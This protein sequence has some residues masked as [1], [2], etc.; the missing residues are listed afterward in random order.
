MGYLLKMF[1][2]RKK[3]DRTIPLSFCPMDGNSKNGRIDWLCLYI[4]NVINDC[5]LPSFADL[6]FQRLQEASLW[7]GKYCKKSEI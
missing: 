1:G 5:T 7:P 3:R 2:I 6:S 4:L